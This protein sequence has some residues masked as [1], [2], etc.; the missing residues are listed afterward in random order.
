MMLE[1]HET[2]WV[3]DL[4][5][6]R[7]CLDFANTVSGIRIYDERDRLAE[8]SDLVSWARQ[9][10]ILDEVQAGKLLTTA[11]DAPQE[12]AATFR[13]ARALREAIYGI[14][15]AF[16]EGRDQ[17]PG[18]LD[19]LNAALKRTLSHRCIEMRGTGEA[20]YALGWEEV[21]GTLD[22]FLWPVVTS[23]AEL[24][25]STDDLS[26]VK[27]CGLF[28]THECGWLFLDETRSRTRRWCSME[29]CGNRAKAR[30]HYQRTKTQP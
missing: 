9:A 24:L 10:T 15:L 28:R 19:I 2:K 18:D 16:A 27:V 22:S 20:R 5:G 8:Y 14:F 29:T 25:V 4:A 11:R 7:L 13:E 1:S 12:A 6:G 30:R 26:R 17:P 21:P 23:A 3:F